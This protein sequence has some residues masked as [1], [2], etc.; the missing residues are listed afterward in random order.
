MK[1]GCIYRVKTADQDYVGLSFVIKDNF[2]I[3]TPQGE[4]IEHL[5]KPENKLD[6]ICNT[7]FTLT[8]FDS[9]EY[10]RAANKRG[11]FKS[12]FNS[13]DSDKVA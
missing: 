13:S 9:I 2:I 1:N 5:N 3:I 11:D 4:I 8:V 6:N 10:L 7:N 12:V